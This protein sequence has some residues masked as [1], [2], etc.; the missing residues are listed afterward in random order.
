MRAR[1]CRRG[2]GAAHGARSAH[3]STALRCG[4]ASGRSARRGRRPHQRAS[5]GSP[6][7]SRTLTTRNPPASFGRAAA[8]RGA[9]A[10][11]SVRSSQQ[12]PIMAERLTPQHPGPGEKRWELSRTSPVERDRVVRRNSTARSSGADGQPC[13][14]AT[15]FCTRRVAGTGAIRRSLANAAKLMC[16][17]SK[18][19]GSAPLVTITNQEQWVCGPVR[20][21]RQ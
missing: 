10:R 6:P 8:S 17:L 20:A 13:H 19:H 18:H 2:Q 16:G 3:S 5:R 11:L 14:L 21:S 7:G 4:R 12:V 1:R 15:F 9:E